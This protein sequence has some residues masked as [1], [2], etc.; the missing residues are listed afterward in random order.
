V[1]YRGKKKLLDFEQ[2]VVLKEA[3]LAAAARALGPIEFA[4][5]QKSIRKAL[6]SK[7]SNLKEIEGTEKVNKMMTTYDREK[8]PNAHEKITGEDIPPRLL[9]YFPYRALGKNSNKPELFKELDFRNL[10]YD[11]KQGV[12]NLQGILKEAEQSRLKTELASELLVRGYASDGMKIPSMIV[13]LKQDCTEKSESTGGKYSV[14]FTKF[15]LKLC[16][17][18]DETIFE[19]QE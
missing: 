14:D 15:F 9:G 16:P 11:N 5:R 7:T 4:K 19:E 13:L 10:E 1:N 18:L 3:Q 6:L 17:H 8:A 2:I 12:R